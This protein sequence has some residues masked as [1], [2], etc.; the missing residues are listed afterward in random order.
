MYRNDT[1]KTL[2]FGVSAEDEMCFAIGFF[3]PDDDAAPLPRG[4]GCFGSGLGL[5]CPLN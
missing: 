5:V 1:S 3:V 2:T 4:P